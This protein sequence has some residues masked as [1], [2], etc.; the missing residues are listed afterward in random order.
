MTSPAKEKG[1]QIVDAVSWSIYQKYEYENADYYDLISQRLNES[2]QKAV[3][4]SIQ[5]K[6]NLARLS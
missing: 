3:L 6:Q 5:E 1:L 2:D 4:L